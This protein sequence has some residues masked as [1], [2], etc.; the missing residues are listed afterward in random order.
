MDGPGYG[1]TIRDRDTRNLGHS[2]CKKPLQE[3]LDELEKPARV[4]Q[5]VE[6]YERRKGRELANRPINPLRPASVSGEDI[7]DLFGEDEGGGA[8][9]VCHK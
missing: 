5:I 3:A 4:I 1:C 2:V 7:D 6:D 9:V 8:C